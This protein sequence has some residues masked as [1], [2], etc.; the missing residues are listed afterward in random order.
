VST[1]LKF[2]TGDSRRYRTV[3]HGTNHQNA[4]F[5]DKHWC[6]HNVQQ[7]QVHQVKTRFFGAFSFQNR[8]LFFSASLHK[9]KIASRESAG[10]GASQK[11]MPY[12]DVVAKVVY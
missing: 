4:K 9:Y 5:Q 6:F 12:F 1:F 11:N 10:L 2:Y 3:K 7:N 8:G